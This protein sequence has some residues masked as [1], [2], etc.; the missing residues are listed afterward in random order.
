MPKDENAVKTAD[1]P[2]GFTFDLDP[3]PGPEESDTADSK[4]S[5]DSKDSGKTKEEK[6]K[7]KDGEKKEI[8]PSPRAG[9]KPKDCGTHIDLD[10]AEKLEELKDKELLQGGLTIED[11]KL[12]RKLQKSV[13]KHRDNTLDCA[14]QAPRREKERELLQDQI[15]WKMQQME[16]LKNGTWRK[17][18]LDLLSTEIGE[19]V[20]EKNNYHISERKPGRILEDS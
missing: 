9:P 6:N 3:A 5:G 13:K 18:K 4:R 20:A 12:M 2:R 19:L 15:S 17:L 16:N 1:E 8:R 10:T 7:K 14:L 11:S